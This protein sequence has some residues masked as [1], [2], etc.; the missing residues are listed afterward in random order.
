MAGPGD[1]SARPSASRRRG[2]SRPRSPSARALRSRRD[3]DSRKA[4]TVLRSSS[5]SSEKAKFMARS[6][7]GWRGSSTVL[8]YTRVPRRRGSVASDIADE[9]PRPFAGLERLSALIVTVDGRPVERR[10]LDAV[11]GHDAGRPDR[12]GA[13]ARRHGRAHPVLATDPVPVW[14]GAG[15]TDCAGDPRRR[16][17]RDLRH[18][19]PPSQGP[20][21]ESLSI[22]W[23]MI[24]LVTGDIFSP[25]HGP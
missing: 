8:V 14:S 2:R 10:P 7:R 20:T 9:P 17:T 12:P 16:S 1:P 3:L 25:R 19:Q 23:R 6:Y 24:V 5:C 11:T 4:R 13:R 18:R 15:S 22:R 21:G